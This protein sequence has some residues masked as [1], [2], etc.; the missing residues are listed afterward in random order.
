MRKFEDGGE[1]GDGGGRR[2]VVLSY[3]HYSTPSC[4]PYTFEFRRVSK[5]VHAFSELLRG[6]LA[7]VVY[8]TYDTS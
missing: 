2:Q 5:N 3:T 8:Y 6:F 1:D 7:H 4:S